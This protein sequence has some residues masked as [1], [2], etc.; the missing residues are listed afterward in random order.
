MDLNNKLKG[1]PHVYYFNLDNRLDRREY[2][3]SQ[4]ERWG[5]EYTRVSASKFLASDVDNWKHLVN[6]ELYGLNVVPD[7]YINVPVT[8]N[9]IAHI[10]FLKNWLE[11]TNDNCLI[12]MEDDYDLNLIEYWH[13]DWQ[14]LMD[15][16]PYDWDCVQL[17]FEAQ[18]YIRFFLHPKPISH[19]H[20]GPCMINRRYAQKIVDLHYVIDENKFNFIQ[21]IGNAEFSLGSNSLPVDYFMCE[22]GRTYC[23]P[24][25]TT[26]PYLPSYDGSEPPRMIAHHV[27]NRL[28]YYDFWTNSRDKFTLKE[29][30]TYN[31]LNDMDMITF[32]QYE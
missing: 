1:M 8:A 4:F 32:V 28:A 13:F 25:I 26:N 19:T 29:F 23:I 18:D 31:K 14:Y 16:I 30:F 15:N 6:G 3:E 12:L 20:F 27:F 10:D 5:I 11:K 22:N 7:E 21:N 24:L 9:A 17:G 2:M